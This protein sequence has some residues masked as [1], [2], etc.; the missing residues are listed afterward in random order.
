MAFNAHSEL[1]RNM[2]QPVLESAI[3]THRT[4]LVSAVTKHHL[5]HAYIRGRAC[6]LCLEFTFLSRITNGTKNDIY[7]YIFLTL[8][9][10]NHG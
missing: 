8:S 4:S 10:A 7:M 6:Q 5:T 2:D 1:V 9:K 3:H